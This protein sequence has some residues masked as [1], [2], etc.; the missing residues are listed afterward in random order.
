MQETKTDGATELYELDVAGKKVTLDLE[1]LKSAAVMG[2]ITCGMREKRQGKDEP[3]RVAALEQ[4]VAA[5]EQNLENKNKSMGSARGDAAADDEMAALEAAYDA[6][7][8]R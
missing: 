6:V 7:F 3:D 1:K 4:R 2:L 5:L 8:S